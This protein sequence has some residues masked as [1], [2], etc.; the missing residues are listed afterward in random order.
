MKLCV[1]KVYC[2]QCK[3]SVRAREESG[4]GQDRI[5]C[6]K[7]DQIIYIGNGVYWRRALPEGEAKPVKEA[8]QSPPAKAGRKRQPKG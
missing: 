1:K 2:P 4:N 5:S 8:E 6:S 3:Q 7:C